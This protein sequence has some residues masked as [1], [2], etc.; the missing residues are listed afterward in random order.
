MT[1]VDH[2][3]VRLYLDQ[4]DWIAL[5]QVRAGKPCAEGVRISAIALAEHIA[6]GDLIAPFSESHVLETGVIGQPTKRQELAAIIMALSRRHAL[7]PLHAL[8]VQEADHFLHRRFGALVDGPPEPFG[9]GLAFAL[10]FSKQEFRPPWPPDAPD[11]DIAMAETFALAEPSRVGLSPEDVERRTRWQSW[12]E[13]LTSASRSIV[14][15]RDRFNEQDRLAAVTLGMLDNALL[16]RAIGHDVHEPFLEFLRAEGPWAVVREMPSLAV[17]TELQ[18]VRYPNTEKAWTMNDYH[19]IRFLSVALAYCDAACPDKFW[20]DLAARSPLI[21]DR[22]IIITTGRYAVAQAL[23]RI[24]ARW[25]R[26]PSNVPRA[27]PIS[28]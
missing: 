22:G 13:F 16:G 9:K 25:D 4:K 28:G 23:D 27:L 17:F 12:A 20:A 18:R 15:D 1:T 14:E 2:P 19:D 11:T 3:P 24:A 5:S 21:V 8:W 7:A 6:R 26:L 10:G